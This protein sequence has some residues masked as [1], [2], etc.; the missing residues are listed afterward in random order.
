MDN[1]II[2]ELDTIIDGQMIK[3]VFQPIIS[4]HNGDVHGYE[5]LSRVTSNESHL[6]NPEQLF[7]AAAAHDRLHALDT[8]CRTISL[9]TFCDLDEDDSTKPLFLNISSLILQ[10]EHFLEHFKTH[11]LDKIGLEPNRIVFEITER[12]SIHHVNRFT[13]SI[14]AL[15]SSGFQVAIDDAGAMYSGLN[16]IT[17]TQPHYVKLDRQLTKNVDFRGINYALIKGLVEFCRMSDIRLVAE[18]VETLAELKCLIDLGVPYAQGFFLQRPAPLLAELSES[19]RGEIINHHT[20][21]NRLYEQPNTSSYIYNICTPTETITRDMNIEQVL[22]KLKKDFESPGLCITENKKV[23]GI[24]TR[25]QLTLQVSG[26]YGFSLYH[27][28]PISLL[29]DK[30]F[31]AIDYRTPINEVSKLAMTRPQ[32]KLYDFIVVTKDDQYLGT[33]TIQN[34]LLKSTEIEVI[35]AKYEN[36]LT[37]LPGNLIIEQKMKRALET[38]DTFSVLYIDINHFKEYNDVYGFE[39]GDAVIKL[40]AD[41]LLLYLP[42]DQ[43]VGHV[44]GDDFVVVMSEVDVADFCHNVSEHFQQK[45]RLHYNEQDR[46]NGYIIAENRLGIM[47]QFPIISISI[48]GTCVQ[49][50]HYLS[51]FDLTKRLAK[52][53]KKSK[54]QKDQHF[55]FIES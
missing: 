47:E 36:P 12:N 18:G 51:V 13:S 16:L 27:K 34:L 1:Q 5:A 28:R 2:R 14:H 43:F 15:K 40:L 11:D 23:I 55:L 19:V 21:R 25:A 38:K 9:H 7:T 31:I 20:K 41:I 30:D 45:V 42:V 17:D 8:L 32:E 10:D 29:M 24:I 6:N 22:E 35:K 52:L 33:V 3:T 49:S 54:R 53:K 4:L 46:V 44:G 26:R 39:N 48:A 50:D 37:G